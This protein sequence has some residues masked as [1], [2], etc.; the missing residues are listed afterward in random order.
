MSR[1]ETS[2]SSRPANTKRVPGA[3]RAT[4]FSSTWPRRA[5]RRKRTSTAASLVIVPTDI[6]CRRASAF[7]STPK[8]PSRSTRRA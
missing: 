8:T 2:S 7:D 3:R 1:I 5:P 4:K 6:R